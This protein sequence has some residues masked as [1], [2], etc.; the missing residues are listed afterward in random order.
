MNKYQKQRSKEI[1]QL[2]MF[3]NF[4]LK[5]YSQARHHWNWLR[6]WTIFSPCIRCCNDCC[7]RNEERPIAYCPNLFTIDI[8]LNRA[9]RL[10][11]QGIITK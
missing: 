4:G 6:K 11:P 10:L 9:L 1:K 3:N 2:L 8:K 5:T 7:K